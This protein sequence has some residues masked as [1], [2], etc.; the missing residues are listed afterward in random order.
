MFLAKQ[1]L[2]SSRSVF[3]FRQEAA[4]R[5][6][7]ATASNIFGFLLHCT[8]KLLL[9]RIPHTLS[10]TKTTAD[11][12]IKGVSLSF[13]GDYERKESAEAITIFLKLREHD[14]VSLLARESLFRRAMFFNAIVTHDDRVTMRTFYSRQNKFRMQ[15]SHEEC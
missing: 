5:R 14:S 11:N 7:F 13:P 15:H 10:K 9:N 1:L 6:G 8:Q 2:A 12:A 4:H 3:P